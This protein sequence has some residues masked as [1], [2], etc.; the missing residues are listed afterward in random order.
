[1]KRL[2]H[3][4]LHPL[5]KHPRQTCPCRVLKRRPPAPQADTLAI[6]TAYSIEYSE[7]LHCCPSLRHVFSVLS[8]YCSHNHIHYC[9]L[10]S[11]NVVRFSYL[12][13]YPN[14][15][16]WSQAITS[17]S[18]LLRD[19]PVLEQPRQA[20]PGP[21][22]NRRPSAPQAD[23]LAKSYC[24]SLFDWHSDPQQYGTLCS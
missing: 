4:H 18:P 23:I 6:S 5:L 11:S 21:G 20:C 3:G 12:H 17:G 15:T 13:F 1:M 10:T 14:S 8:N 2:D 9:R 7:P 19:L 22:L 16:A 24:N